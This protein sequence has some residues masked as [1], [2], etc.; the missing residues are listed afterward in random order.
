MTSVVAPRLKLKADG[1]RVLIES[2]NTKHKVENK[3]DVNLKDL[4]SKTLVG[5]LISYVIFT[6]V[7]TA[8]SGR[9]AAIDH[10][11]AISIAL[12]GVALSLI[13]LLRIKSVYRKK[14]LVFLLNTPIL[15][16]YVH[17]ATLLIPLCFFVPTVLCL[18]FSFSSN[19]IWQLLCILSYFAS[20]FLAQR[21]LIGQ[22]S[23][24]NTP[25]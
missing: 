1:S 9:L 11:L 6:I 22:L 24:A 20:L 3:V 13:F 19:S 14:W 25:A 17:I 5:F 18:E 7:I 4:I 8:K 16:S 23:N 12:A 15:G 10:F 21:N 2:W